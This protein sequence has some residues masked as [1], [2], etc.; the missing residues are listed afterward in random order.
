M[1]SG[2]AS[3]SS[4]LQKVIDTKYLGSRIF[5]I[6][7]G[8]SMSFME[9]QVLGYKSPLYGRRTAQLKIQPF[10]YLDSSNF[11]VDYTLEE[12][13][14]AFAIVGGIPQYLKNLAREGDL[15]NAIYHNFL[16][17][18]GHLFEEPTSILKQELREPAMYNSN[19]FE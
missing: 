12:K 15:F 18:D 11:F 17:K 9:N 4:V 6:L 5:L 2:N 13:L 3:I 10:D 8:S 14:L 19:R 1:A 7:S 16:R